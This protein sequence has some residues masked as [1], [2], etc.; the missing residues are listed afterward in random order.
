MMKDS[1]FKYIH[2]ISVLYSIVLFLLKI[3]QKLFF[4]HQEILYFLLLIFRVSYLR[5][6]FVHVINLEKDLKSKLVIYSFSR[7]IDEISNIWWV[8]NTT[9]KK[10]VKT[11][12]IKCFCSSVFFLLLNYYSLNSTYE[13]ERDTV[14]VSWIQR[15][16]YTHTK[17]NR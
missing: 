5:I 7:K 17:H 15:E 10:D 9:G 1:G 11:K 2:S 6:Y 14:A 16:F 3:L 4:E 8:I 13:N 12:W